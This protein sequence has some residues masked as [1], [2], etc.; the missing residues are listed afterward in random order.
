[1]PA[2]AVPGHGS[3]VMCGPATGAKLV[4]ASAIAFDASGNLFIAEGG[5]TRNTPGAIRK[6]NTGGTIST[7]AGSNTTITGTSTT[8]LAYPNGITVAP[9]GKIYVALG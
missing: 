2:V 7:L 1:M 5:D 9:D 8:G 3:T 4:A 6:V